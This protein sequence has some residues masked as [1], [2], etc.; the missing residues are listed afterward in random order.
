MICGQAD[1]RSVSHQGPGRSPDLPVPWRRRSALGCRKLLPVRE[2][3][4]HWPLAPEQVTHSQAGH[5]KVAAEPPVSGCA[6]RCC[7]CSQA[8]GSYRILQ[9]ALHI[10]DFDLVEKDVLHDASWIMTSLRAVGER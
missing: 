2:G 10:G 3:L 1:K 4:Q 6:T 5:G 8:V 9:S 7:V